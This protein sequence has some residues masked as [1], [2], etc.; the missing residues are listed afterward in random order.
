MMSLRSLEGGSSSRARDRA[1]GPTCKVRNE[2]VVVCL[3]ARTGEGLYDNLT[4]AAYGAL[5]AEK[6]LGDQPGCV[7]SFEHGSV[8]V[9]PVKYGVPFFGRRELEQTRGRLGVGATTCAGAGESECDGGSTED[10]QVRRCPE[11]GSAQDGR[12]VRAAGGWMGSENGGTRTLR[13]G[14]PPHVDA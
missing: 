1:P 4:V 7:Q 9:K 5:V 11:S 3:I 6:R 2:H 10:V 12:H 14:R 8:L 13:E